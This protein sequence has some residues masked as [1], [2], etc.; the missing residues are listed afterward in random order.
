MGIVKHFSKIV[1]ALNWNT[2]T[3]FPKPATAFEG[4]VTTGDTRVKGSRVIDLS[5]CVKHEP[6]KLQEDVREDTKEKGLWSG[7]DLV[8]VRGSGGNGGRED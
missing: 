6:E 2:P 8:V 7:G 5:V 4:P 1:Q 3:V